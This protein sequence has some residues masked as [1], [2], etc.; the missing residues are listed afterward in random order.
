[1]AFTGNEMIKA[2]DNAGLSDD[3]TNRFERAAFAGYLAD[4][5]GADDETAEETLVDLKTSHTHYEGD[6]I[7]FWTRDLME[8]REKADA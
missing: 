7:T 3:L 1:M 4:A 2:I 8:Y 5:Y 6:R